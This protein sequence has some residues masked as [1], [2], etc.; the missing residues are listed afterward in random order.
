MEVMFRPW[1]MTWIWDFGLY[2]FMWARMSLSHTH[3]LHSHM[4]LYVWST[5]NGCP[6]LAKPHNICGIFF[7]FCAF[8]TWDPL[9]CSESPISLEQYGTVW[10]SIFREHF[11]ENTSR[12]TFRESTLGRSTHSQ[13]YTANDNYLRDD[14]QYI[15]TIK[16][17][18]SLTLSHFIF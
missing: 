12:T 13:D 11:E 15:Y 4:L 5:Q 14:L 6:S 18:K 9:S 10:K 3:T 2:A 1:L 16:Y 8:L 7:P 17:M